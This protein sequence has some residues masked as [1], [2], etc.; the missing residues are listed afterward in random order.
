MCLTNSLYSILSD[1]LPIL[2][3][4]FLVRLW[5]YIGYLMISNQPQLKKDA[6]YIKYNGQLFVEKM[7]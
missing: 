1:E 2:D 6:N 3:S 4:V 7:M 5:L